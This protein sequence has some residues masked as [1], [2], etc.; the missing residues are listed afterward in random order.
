MTNAYAQMQILLDV[1]A[2]LLQLTEDMSSGDD[3]HYDPANELDEIIQQVEEAIGCNPET[4]SS[5][6]MVHCKDCTYL[7]LCRCPMA[8]AFDPYLPAP[9]G[10]CYL[11]TTDDIDDWPE[12]HRRDSND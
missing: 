3:L 6:H 5:A 9:D 7:R 11:G 2:R 10:Y 4:D 1:R 12:P 8:E